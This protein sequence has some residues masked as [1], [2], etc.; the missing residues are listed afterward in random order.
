MMMSKIKISVLCSVFVSSLFL[1]NI[2][3][4]QTA[5][6]GGA[7]NTAPSKATQK[8]TKKKS[9]VKSIRRQYQNNFATPA[10]ANSPFA[11][12]YSLSGIVSDMNRRATTGVIVRSLP[13][14]TI[15]YQNDAETLYTPASN[16]KILTAFAALKFLGP[17]FRFHTQILT[18]APSANPV[19]GVLHGNVY[20]K[21]EGDPTLTLETMNALAHQLVLRGIRTIEG[22]LYVDSTCF[23]RQGIAPGT[24]LHDRAY[25]YGAPINSATL[26]RN[27]ITIKILPGIPGGPARIIAP[28]DIRLP[29]ENSI[30]TQNGGG[31]RVTIKQGENGKSFLDGYISTRRA[32]MPMT[33]TI[34]PGDEYGQNV[35]AKLLARNGVTVLGDSLPTDASHLKLLASHDSADLANLVVQMMKRSDNLFANSLFKTV[36]AHYNKASASWENSGIAVKNILHASG[37]DTTGMVVIDGSGLSR[38]DRVSPDQF[39]QILV[40]AYKNPEIYNDF[41]RALPVGGLNGT[42]RNRLGSRDIVGKVRAKTGSMHGVSSLSGYVETRNGQTLA[43]SIV[44]ND[45]VGALYPYRAMEDKLCRALSAQY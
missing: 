21:Y 36:G 22:A 29:L 42:L 10:N 39:S 17:E 9:R 43:F 45:F 15:I 4:A 27:C 11:N 13:A 41:L 16:M 7:Q 2:V 37:V 30:I 14:G 12:A 26:N 28:Y 44:V 8:T 31:C 24:E 25:C 23:D 19:N 3:N 40:A 20:V 33:I 6:N 35:A 5:T 32:G 34:P 38:N 1:G 18:D